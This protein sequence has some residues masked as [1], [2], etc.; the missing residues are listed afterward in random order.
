MALW[1]GR[2]AEATQNSVR[3]FTESISYDK[4]LYKYDI[5]GSKAHATMLAEQKIIPESSAKAIC[6][7]LGKLPTEQALEKIYCT[8]GIKASLPDIDVPAAAQQ[9]LLQYAPMV[10]NRLTLMRLRSCLHA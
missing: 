7:E 3:D 9:A 2:F 10:R 1:G 5:M 6:E 4:R 8:M